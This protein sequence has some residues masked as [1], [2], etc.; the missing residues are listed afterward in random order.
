MPL[1]AHSNGASVF[2]FLVF[3]PDFAVVAEHDE[4][5]LEGVGSDAWFLAG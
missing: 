2:H 3:Q 5:V 4:V 1:R